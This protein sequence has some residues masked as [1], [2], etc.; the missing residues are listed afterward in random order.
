M[1]TRTSARRRAVAQSMPM[2]VHTC[3]GRAPPPKLLLSLHY[4]P[5]RLPSLAV[6]LG[7][8]RWRL[9]LPVHQTS[10]RPRHAICNIEYEDIDF[11]A[12]TFTSYGGF[13]TSTHA[14]INKMT[15]EAYPCDFDPW[16]RPGPKTH[17]Y[18]R[19]GFAL[20][21]ANARMLLHADSKR[22]SSQ[23]RVRTSRSRSPTDVFSS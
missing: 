17:A 22:R 6:T 23:N 8:R 9:W 12:I 5:D 3:S 14:L 1:A 7:R 11:R 4:C 16:R 18:L 19:F 13:G 15:S 21:R 20:A 10:H 2:R